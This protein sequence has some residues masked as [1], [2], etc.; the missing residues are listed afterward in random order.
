MIPK[1]ARLPAGRRW[2]QSEL[3]AGSEGAGRAEI[4][5]HWGHSSRR[6]EET[7]Q[8]HFRG[9]SYKGEAS[10]AGCG[11]RESPGERRAPPV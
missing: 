1:T 3:Y 6:S 5:S 11:R 8:V 10:Q 4:L 7:L 2:A 9:K